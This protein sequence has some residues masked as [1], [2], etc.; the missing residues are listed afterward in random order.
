[1]FY[2]NEIHK[3]IEY[4]NKFKDDYEIQKLRYRLIFDMLENLIDKK[5]DCENFIQRTE[6]YEVLFSKFCS[7]TKF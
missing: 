1:M 3:N 6:Y 7:K 2:K 5:I 4:L